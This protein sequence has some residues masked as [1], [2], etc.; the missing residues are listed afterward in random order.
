MQDGNDLKWE[1]YG[2]RMLLNLYSL[3]EHE[4]LCDLMLVAD[5]ET[6]NVHRAVM[7]ASS[8]YF[9]AMLT[10]DMKEKGQRIVNLKGM[11]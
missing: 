11:L 4:M 9:K 1:G 2:N 5:N 8:D 6:F 7:A 3:K 10:L